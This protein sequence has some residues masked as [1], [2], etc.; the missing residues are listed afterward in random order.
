M[1]TSDIIDLYKS[2]IVQIATPTAT[3]T[4]FYLKEYDIIVTNHHVVKNYGDVSVKAKN[5]EK[6]LARVVFMDSKY[7]LA[8]LMLATTVSMPS[9][10]LALTYPNKDGEEVLAIGH[11]YGLSYTTTQG[12]ISKADRL[13]NGLKYIQVDAA[14]NPG[15]SGGPLVNMD[16]DVLGINTFIIRGGDN[17]GF[18]LPADQIDIALRQYQQVR[19][20]SVVRCSS[21]STLVTA[22]NIERKEYCPSCGAEVELIAYNTDKIEPTGIAKKIEDI[23]IALGKD[24][25]LARISNNY[26]EIIEGD[27][28]IKISYNAEQLIV[29]GYAHL[30]LLPK[31][32]SSKCFEYI[33]HENYQLKDILFSVSEKEIILSFIS[34]N[35]D[36]SLE[37]GKEL[38]RELFSKAN[39]YTA[40]LIKEYNCLPLLEES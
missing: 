13:Y 14:I 12:V 17:L 2:A 26:W 4:G 5:I 20:T 34:H 1:L 30:C 16:G 39:S 10:Q 3:G 22:Q 18:A 33:L 36:M 21:C 7:D 9:I 38:F 23:F 40:I 32:N 31:E 11:P 37:Y 24:H 15:N 6:Q 28:N 29:S 35:I 25:I 27:T 8:F 19:G